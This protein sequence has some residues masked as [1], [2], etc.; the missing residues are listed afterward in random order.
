VSTQD[1]ACSRGVPIEARLGSPGCRAD[2]Y[3]LRPCL[4]FEPSLHTS[5]T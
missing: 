3:Q 5:K 1:V 2:N 4:S